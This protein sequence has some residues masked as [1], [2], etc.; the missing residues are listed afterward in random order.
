MQP[1]AAFHCKIMS[2]DG[3]RRGNI[4]GI[5]IFS[6]GNNGI[7]ASLVSFNIILERDPEANIVIHTACADLFKKYFYFSFAI[8]AVYTFNCLFGNPPYF[9]EIISLRAPAFYIK[10]AR[11]IPGII[12]EGFVENSF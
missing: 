12:N 8:V 9:I 5:K 11:A 10:P 6:H 1:F 4:V 3:E 7:I 2:T